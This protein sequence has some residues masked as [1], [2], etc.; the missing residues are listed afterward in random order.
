M[1]VLIHLATTF[2]GFSQDSTQLRKEWKK[3]HDS[4]ASLYKN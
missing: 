2:T 4:K 1:I 3:M